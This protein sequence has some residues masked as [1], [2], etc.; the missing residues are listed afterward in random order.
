MRRI[1]IGYEI[2]SV[3]DILKDLSKIRS[4]SDEDLTTLIEAVY[5]SGYDDGSEDGYE[6]GYDD[7]WSDH[8]TD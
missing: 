6:N 3:D 4:M 8:S 2:T 1:V 7:G 5:D